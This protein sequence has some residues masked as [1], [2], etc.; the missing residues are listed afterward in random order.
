MRGKLDYTK[1]DLE[2]LLKMSKTEIDP[3]YSVRE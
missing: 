1:E 3:Y 2:P